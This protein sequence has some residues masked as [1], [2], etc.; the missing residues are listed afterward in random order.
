MCVCV[1]AY[2]HVYAYAIVFVCIVHVPNMHTS[3][4]CAWI[5]L[6]INKDAFQGKEQKL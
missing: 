1:H 3:V 4:F 2:V 5:C 6:N